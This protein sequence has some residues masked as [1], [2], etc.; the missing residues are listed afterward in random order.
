MGR[1]SDQIDAAIAQHL[2]RPVDRK[3]ELDRHVETF[4]LEESELDCRG[5]GE[6]GIGD[7]VWNGDLHHLVSLAQGTITIAWKVSAAARTEWSLASECGLRT[8]SRRFCHDSD[9]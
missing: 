9:T 5:C 3:D 7:Q 8:Q 2:E 4:L 1:P 6:I